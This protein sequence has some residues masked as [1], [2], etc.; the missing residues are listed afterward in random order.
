LKLQFSTNYLSI[1]YLDDNS[2]CP[3]I[4]VLGGNV[5]CLG[6]SEANEG[7]VYY[8][9]MD[10]GLYELNQTIEE[11]KKKLIHYDSNF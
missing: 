3:I 6:F 4:E 5:I 10:F 8:F 1:P 2:V 9:D 11:F 7:K